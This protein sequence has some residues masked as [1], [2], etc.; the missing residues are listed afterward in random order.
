MR[1]ATQIYVNPLNLEKDFVKTSHN[2]YR[3]NKAID[4]LDM[5]I[6]K[7]IKS[8][9]KGD[10]FN[11]EEIRKKVAEF[12]Q[13]VNNV[14]NKLEK[15]KR[16]V[17]SLE[18]QKLIRIYN[19]I[20]IE[21]RKKNIVSKEIG[22]IQ[23]KVLY[24]IRD[25]VN[26]FLKAS[27][28]LYHD[29]EPRGYYLTK[30][31][32]TGFLDRI[33][34]RLGRKLEREEMKETILESKIGEAISAIPDNPSG[35]DIENLKKKINDLFRSYLKSFNMILRIEIDIDV[36]EARRLHK[37]EQYIN[38]LKKISQKDFQEQIQQ[39]MVLRYRVNEWVKQDYGEASRLKIMVDNVLNLEVNIKKIAEFTDDFSHIMSW[40]LNIGTSHGTIY[41][42]SLKHN[43]KGLVLFHG[44][45]G[46]NFGLDLFA[47]RCA[48]RGYTVL[49][50]NL[51]LHHLDKSHFRLGIAS[52]YVLTG[53]NYLRTKCKVSKVGVVAHSAGAASSMFAA[54][55]YN[56]KLELEIYWLVEKIIELI[57]DNEGIIKKYYNKKEDVRTLDKTLAPFE[58]PYTK[59]KR[60]IL[61]SIKSGTLNNAKI[62]AF[63]FLA[64]P[65]DMSTTLPGVDLL[66]RFSPVTVKKIFNIVQGGFVKEM[67]REGN[68]MNWQGN[69]EGYIIWQHFYLKF[70]DMHSFAKYL[71]NIKNPC[72]YMN[73]INY[74]ASLPNEKENARFINYFRRKYIYDI[75][76]LFMYGTLDM[77]VRPFFSEKGKLESVYSMFGNHQIIRIKGMAHFLNKDKFEL[78]SSY[79]LQSS[80]IAHT[81]F[82]FLD[83]NL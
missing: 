65:R 55:N 10:R 77:M 49:S 9:K 78:Q 38:F 62:D 57:K 64:A 40:P 43:N 31:H 32:G 72:D 4:V 29:K 61:E 14:L 81:I 59:L 83:Q 66:R 48:N 6:L 15:E 75:P 74:F 71:L 69:K 28:R 24:Y 17:E 46:N 7:L 34:K 68:P 41:I 70:E 21:L 8:S 13:I 44:F 3:Q 27:K 67:A 26:Q 30:I 63:V 60:D 79:G 51:P 23:S 33:G 1:K 53:A 25:D 12:M 54:C 52:E 82:N 56:H 58:E 73:L 76:K 22:E 2:L 11:I 5:D 20:K 35:K 45:L 42:D 47:K 19:W 50:L 39:L 36:E 18:Y 16:E 80:K 37:I